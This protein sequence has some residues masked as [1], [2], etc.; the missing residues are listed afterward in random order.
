MKSKILILDNKIHP[1]S[2]ISNFLTQKKF[3]VV[4]PSETQSVFTICTMANLRA[5]IVDLSLFGEKSSVFLQNLTE[6]VL[7]ENVKL[8]TI[9]DRTSPRQIFDKIRL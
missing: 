1:L 7:P 2:T 5:V 8:I 9:S 6:N 3:E 4:K